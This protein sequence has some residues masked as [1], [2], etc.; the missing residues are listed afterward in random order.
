MREARGEGVVYP[1]HDGQQR[2][3]HMRQVTE[4][5]GGGEFVATSASRATY[6]HGARRKGGGPHPD[7]QPRQR[8]LAQEAPAP[9]TDS[10]GTADRAWQVHGRGRMNR[11]PNRRV[12]ET[13]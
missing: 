13:S 11:L 3:D 2:P 9:F 10:V 1:D 12:Q 4:A 8:A 5:F 7:T 6:D